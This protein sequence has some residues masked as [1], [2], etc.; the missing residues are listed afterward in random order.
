[1][2]EAREHDFTPIGTRLEG[3]YETDRNADSRDLFKAILKEVFGPPT[4]DMDTIIGHHLSYEWREK[5][6]DG[7]VYTFVQEIPSAD[8]LIFDHGVAQKL[9]GDKY[10]HVLEALARTPVDKRDAFLGVLYA[11]RPDSLR[12]FATETL[13][14]P[15][16]S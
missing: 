13:G 10:L 12:Q 7:F 8:A 5:R 1:M 9:W 15:C 3:Q 6:A 14:N 11:G 16:A 4:G 2:S